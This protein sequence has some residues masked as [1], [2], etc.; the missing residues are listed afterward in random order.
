[1]THLIDADVLGAPEPPGAKVAGRFG[2][3]GVAAGL[4]CT[5]T[6]GG[7]VV[8]I[9]ATRMSGCGALTLTGRLGEVAQESARTSLSWLRANAAYYGVDPAFHRDTDLHLHVQADAAF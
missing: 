7:E 2:P 3:P 1:M 6:G 8:F 4:G 5:T 9:E